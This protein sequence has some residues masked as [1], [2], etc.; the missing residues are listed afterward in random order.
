MC[1]DN[2]KARGV[3]EVLPQN[4]YKTG[5]KDGKSPTTRLGPPLSV[6][7]SRPPKFFAVLTHLCRLPLPR[8][9]HRTSS[10]LC[11]PSPSAF[12]LQLRFA[13]NQGTTPPATMLPHPSPVLPLPSPL[14][15]LWLCSDSLSLSLSCLPR[16]END[17]KALILGQNSHGQLHAS[18]KWEVT[19]DIFE[20]LVQGFF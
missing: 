14:R 5:P 8:L 7:G 13:L 15:P 18:W 1:C 12:T 16:V 2:Y 4:S 11:W 17:H 19:F 6:T 10:L 20:G 9:S 3:H